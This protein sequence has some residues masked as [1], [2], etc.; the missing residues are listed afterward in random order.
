MTTRSL[1]STFLLSAV[2]V[3]AAPNNAQVEYASGTVKALPAKTQ[4]T[5]DVDD[6]KEF[7]FHYKD[8]VYA[9][10]Y[11]RIDSAAKGRPTSIA[12]K[13]KGVPGVFSRHK[14]EYLTVSF[15]DDNG[16][17]QVMTFALSRQTLDQALPALQSKTGAGVQR[18]DEWWGDK[19]WKTDR[20]LD[21]WKNGKA[22][23]AKR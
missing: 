12:G 1:L 21:R 5:L 4:G 8:T 14:S 7:R 23:T 13:L 15:R 10:P 11:D 16:A 2:V 6:S 19:Y 22:E 9:V 3:W 18:Q 20:N 17:S